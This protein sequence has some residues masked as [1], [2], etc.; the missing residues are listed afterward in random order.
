M[1][2]MKYTLIASLLLTAACMTSSEKA[3]RYCDANWQG[4]YDSW[5]LCYDDQLPQQNKGLKALGA[6]LSGAGQGM[7]NASHSR[8]QTCYT[9]GSSYNGQYSAQTNCR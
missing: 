6:V 3:S 8:S 1:P 9:T 7:Q 2:K 4:R 5:Q